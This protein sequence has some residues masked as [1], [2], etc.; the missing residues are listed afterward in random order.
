[1][2]LRV[3]YEDLYSTS[4]YFQGQLLQTDLLSSAQEILC[5]LCIPK[6]RFRLHSDQPDRPH[7]S[8]LA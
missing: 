5:V 6:L 3:I 1:M 4:L 2:K 7:Q 8:F